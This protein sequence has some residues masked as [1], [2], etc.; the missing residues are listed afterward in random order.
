MFEKKF[1]TMDYQP[2]K[3][4]I[5][6]ITSEQEEQ[7]LA[8]TEK[9]TKLM[10]ELLD[11]LKMYAG[12]K[13]KIRVDKK[14]TVGSSGKKLKEI[15]LESKD[16]IINCKIEYESWTYIGRR[17]GF[18]HSVN[19][20]FKLNSKKEQDIEEYLG[21]AKIIEGTIDRNKEIIKEVY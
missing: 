19:I 16:G 17:P 1:E 15:I 20:D 3:K 9:G 11:T 12:Q 4:Y 18:I 5:H 13:R 21:I 6:I 14:M 10:T 2:I 8:A 7:S